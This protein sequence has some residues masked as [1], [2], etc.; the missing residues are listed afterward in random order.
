M[1]KFEWNKD[2]IKDLNIILTHHQ[3]HLPHNGIPHDLHQKSL[4][5]LMYLFINNHQ[6]PGANITISSN[7]LKQ[8][9]SIPSISNVLQMIAQTNNFENDTLHYDDIIDLQQLLQFL[10]RLQ[11]ELGSDFIEPIQLFL[12]AQNYLNNLLNSIENNFDWYQNL[13]DIL[14]V[15]DLHL[16]SSVIDTDGSIINYH[17]I[18]QLQDEI[19]PHLKVIKSNTAIFFTAVAK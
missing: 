19:L 2:L 15:N 11:L 13:R 16:S 3:Y 12:F 4:I 5:T 10:Y 17:Q 6:I 1:E 18:S 8:S 7:N 9:I 14:D